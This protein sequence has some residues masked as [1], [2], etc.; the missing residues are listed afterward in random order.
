MALL[1]RQSI[2]YVQKI[3]QLYRPWWVTPWP[4]SAGTDWYQA[5]TSTNHHSEEFIF[6]VKR[7]HWQLVLPDF[8]ST[9]RNI[10]SR[11]LIFAW[12]PLRRRYGVDWAFLRL[13][14]IRRFKEDGPHIIKLKSVSILYL[15]SLT[16]LC[17]QSGPPV[18]RISLQYYYRCQFEIITYG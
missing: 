1:M 4:H 13:T 11:G 8:I 9:T 6:N 3:G 15:L 7:T 14:Q 10:I 12:T 5:W 18:R 16:L 2:A 17:F